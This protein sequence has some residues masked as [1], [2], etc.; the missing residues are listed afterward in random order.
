[1]LFAMHAGVR[2]AELNVPKA[3]RTVWCF[4]LFPAEGPRLEDIE[5]PPR[6]SEW[7]HGLLQGP[8]AAAAS[9]AVA[10]ECLLSVDAEACPLFLPCTPTRATQARCARASAMS[11]H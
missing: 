1:M 8:R 10:S 7:A 3:R 4:C 11:P 5:P 9:Q 6:A 2:F